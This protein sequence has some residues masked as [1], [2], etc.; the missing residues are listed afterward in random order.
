MEP[1][2]G[3]VRIHIEMKPDRP[4]WPQDSLTDAWLAGIVEARAKANEQ[5]DVWDTPSSDST[6]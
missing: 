4:V 2:A 5:T 3:V 1:T 6:E